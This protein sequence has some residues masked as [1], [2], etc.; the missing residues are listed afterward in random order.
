MHHI[1]SHLKTGENNFYCKDQDY[2]YDACHSVWKN[3]KVEYQQA[4]IQIINSFVAE[5]SEG[6]YCTKAVV[7]KL[8]LY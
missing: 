1:I 6:T 7:A 3:M 4:V 2:Y 5:S 8:S